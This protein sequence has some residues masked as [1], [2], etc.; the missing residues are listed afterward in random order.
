M[1][2]PE[3]VAYFERY[4][5]SFAA[6]VRT[7]T[8][9]VDAV[10]R[11]GRRLPRRDHRAATGWRATVVIATGYSDRPAV[12][13]VAARACRRHSPGRADATTG[14]PRELAGRRRAGRRRVGVRRPDRRRAPSVRPRRDDRRRPPHPAAARLPRARHPV[15]ARS[16]GRVRR[17]RRSGLRRRSRASS[18]RCSWS[19]TRPR[20]ARPGEP[21]PTAA[22]GSSAGCS[23]CATAWRWFAD[24]LVATTAAADIKL[25]SLLRRIDAIHRPT[26]AH[27]AD[28]PTPFEPHCLRFVE[29]GHAS[30]TCRTPA[31]DGGLGDRLPPRLPVAAAAGARRARRDP[32]RGGVTPAPGSVRARPALPAPA[33]VELHRR[34]RRRARGLSVAHGGL[35]RRRRVRGGGLIG[36][37]ASMHRT[38]RRSCRAATTSSSW[39]RGRPAPAT[40]LLL[41]RHGAARADG[42]SRPIRHRH[43][44]DARAD[45]RRRAAARPMGRAARGSCRRHATGETSHVHLRR[46]RAGGRGQASRRRRRAVRA[47]AHRARPHA[48]GCRRRSRRGCRLRRASHRPASPTRRAGE[49]HRHDRRG[50]HGARCRGGPW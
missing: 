49:R 16:H 15:V 24:D 32:P 48:R 10:T 36:A 12:P 42:R 37:S 47:A 27:R 2:M 9:T 25:A 40:A 20:H 3:V 29:R 41:A 21:A 26:G 13:P 50:R 30:S 43:A 23:T 5:A 17:D 6:P 39:A 8:S 44:V 46:R 18:R 7:E 19:A 22:C 35:R 31:S 11:D 38:Q 33:E 45:A 14:V 1:T 4:A 34:R 28:P